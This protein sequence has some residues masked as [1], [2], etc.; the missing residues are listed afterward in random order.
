MPTSLTENAANADFATG[1]PV[2]ANGDNGS[3][4]GPQVIVG[5]QEIVDRTQWLKGWIQ[6][7]PSIVIPLLMQGNLSTRFSGTVFTPDNY[8]Y[9][10]QTNV[11]TAGLAWFPIAGRLPVGRKITGATAYWFNTNTTTMPAVK[12]K[13]SIAKKSKTLTNWFTT[14]YTV[15][16]SLTDPTTVVATYNQS[17]AI[18]L[19]GLSETIADGTEYHVTFEGETSTNSTSGGVLLSLTVQLAY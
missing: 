11:S 2:P 7:T 14:A 19:T 10:E 1:L 12:P 18:A 6:T 3:S 4:W 15:V 9:I 16:G 8:P 13:L 17:H 5:L